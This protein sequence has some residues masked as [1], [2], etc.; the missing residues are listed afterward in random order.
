MH[1]SFNTPEYTFE[2]CGNWGSI[3]F[4]HLFEE[5]EKRARRSAAC[6]NRYVRALPPCVHSVDI[7][8]GVRKCQPCLYLLK[9]AARVC[10]ITAMKLS[11]ES[12]YKIFYILFSHTFAAPAWM[13]SESIDRVPTASLARSFFNLAVLC[14]CGCG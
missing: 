7:V 6:S 10:A 8:L 3:K 9:G 11:L 4:R 5:G 1:S 13:G 14:W 2:I 12:E